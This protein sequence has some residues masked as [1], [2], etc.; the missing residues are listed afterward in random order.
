[1]FA[2]CRERVAGVNA[3]KAG[4]FAQGGHRYHEEVAGEAQVPRLSLGAGEDD[5]LQDDQTHSPTGEACKMCKYS[6]LE[7]GRNLPNHCLGVNTGFPSVVFAS[8]LGTIFLPAFV[9]LMIVRCNFDNN[10]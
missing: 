8:K 2:N 5:S 3:K 6:W 4:K 9:E 10:C 1:M 7:N